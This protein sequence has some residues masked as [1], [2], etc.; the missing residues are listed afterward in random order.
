MLFRFSPFLIARKCSVSHDSEHFYVVWRRFRC[1][2]APCGG[3]FRCIYT[4]GAVILCIFINIGAF[5]ENI[6]PKERKTLDFAVYVC[7]A[8]IVK[9][10]GGAV[11]NKNT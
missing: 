9:E 5:L 8:G 10:N 7:Y 3:V 11:A 4:R 1:V 2:Y 6:S